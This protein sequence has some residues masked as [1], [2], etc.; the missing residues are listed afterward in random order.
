MNE[1]QLEEM[2]LQWWASSYPNAKPG[3]HSVF[4]H[5]AFTAWLLRGEAIPKIDD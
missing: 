5:V 1:Q 4:T 2:F 3:P